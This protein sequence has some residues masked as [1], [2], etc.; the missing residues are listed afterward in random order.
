M[1]NGLIAVG[2]ARLALCDPDCR[3]RYDLSCPTRRTTRSP[4]STARPSRRSRRSRS[5]SARG[6]SSCRR[7]QRRSTSAPATATILR[8][9]ISPATTSSARLPSGTDPEFFALDPGGKLLYIAN[10]NNNIV[11]VVDVDRGE[12]VTEI[13]VGVEPEGMGISPDGRYLVNTSETTS[14]AHVIDTVTRKIIANMLVDSRPR[15]AVWTADGAQF[16]V[17]SEIGGTVSVIDAA[18]PQSSSGS[19]S[20]CRACRTRQFSRSGLRSPTTA[21]SPSSRWGLP[22]ALPS[23]MR[24][25]MR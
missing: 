1:P 2:C 25:A 18:T 15:R 17:S 22:I 8:C 4:S 6:A 20:R 21:S 9:S 14:M 7:M 3:G 16:W 19:P 5:A 13:P 10:E 24:G 23:S 12:V 11:T